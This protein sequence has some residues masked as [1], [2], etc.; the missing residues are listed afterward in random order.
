MEPDEFLNEEKT[1]FSIICNISANYSH[2]VEFL[3]R[4]DKYERF[5]SLKNISSVKE[6]LFTWV[7]PLYRNR[8][9]E[10]NGEYLCRDNNTNF[11]IAANITCKHI[12][13]YCTCIIRNVF[14]VLK[15]FSYIL[16]S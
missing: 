10:S 4:S 14:F 7:A 6:S 12:S 13:L 2:I 3:F 16:T 11:T 5:V 8:Q 15:L 9:R 1:N